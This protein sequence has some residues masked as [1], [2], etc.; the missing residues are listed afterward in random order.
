MSGSSGKLLKHLIRC[1]NPGT[2]Q[3]S[4]TQTK[5]VYFLF[6]DLMQQIWSWWTCKYKTLLLKCWPQNS[7]S[8]EEIISK[9]DLYRWSYHI[10]ILFVN[11]VVN[12]KPVM[13]LV[14]SCFF[15]MFF[16]RSVWEDS[17]ILNHLKGG[18]LEMVDVTK[19]HG[20]A[21]KID[22]KVLCVP[23]DLPLRNGVFFCILLHRD[24]Q[25][26]L[27]YMFCSN[28][29]MYNISFHIDTHIIQYSHIWDCCLYMSF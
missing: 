18:N 5:T 4:H 13:F 16:W 8:Y 20:G 12:S 22:T 9:Y 25:Y 14:S 23:W 29:H 7:I 6:M 21:W 19:N 26:M 27:M 11:L 17:K 3:K 28:I 2:W 1:N 10:W 15:L 24:W